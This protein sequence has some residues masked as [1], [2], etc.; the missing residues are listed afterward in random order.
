MTVSSVAVLGRR[1]DLGRSVAKTVER[2]PLLVRLHH[3]E[4]LALGS[5]V[6]GRI[7]SLLENLLKEIP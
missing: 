4:V 5:K 7:R 1:H 3:D 2:N 6:A